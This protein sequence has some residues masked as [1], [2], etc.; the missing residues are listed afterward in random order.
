LIFNL[1][2]LDLE[3]EEED[4]CITPYSEPEPEEP[5]DC[6]ENEDLNAALPGLKQHKNNNLSFKGPPPPPPPP[7][8]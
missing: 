2:S 5:L 6:N 4:Y 8:R 7:S 1:G 3:M